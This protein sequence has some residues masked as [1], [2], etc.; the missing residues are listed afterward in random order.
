MLL[1]LRFG[2][3][4]L[5][6]LDG[7]DGPSEK[8]GDGQ[9]FDPSDIEALVEDEVVGKLVELFARSG[10]KKPRITSLMARASSREHCASNGPWLCSTIRRSAYFS[11][12]P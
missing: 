12:I 4:A 3:P 8:L 1:S 10:Q 5:A 6:V 2:R 7:A 11:M 9:V